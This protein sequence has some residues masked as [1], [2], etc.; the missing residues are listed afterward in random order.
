MAGVPR[1]AVPCHAARA[2]RSTRRAPAAGVRRLP[3]PG[4]TSLEAL[5]AARSLRRHGR[6]SCRGAGG[7]GPCSPSCARSSV[8]RGRATRLRCRAPARNAE[9]ARASDP[10]TMTTDGPRP[11]HRSRA[12]TRPAST[13]DVATIRARRRGRPPDRRRGPAT[14]ASAMRGRPRGAGRGRRRRSDLRTSLVG[15]D[16][17]RDYPTAG[18]SRVTR[19]P[20]DEHGRGDGSGRSR[21]SAG[22]DRRG[23]RRGRDEPGRAGRSGSPIRPRR[24]AEAR[25][26]AVADA[27]AR[28]TVLAGEA[29]GVTL[30][31]VVAI[32]EGVA[33]APPGRRGRWRR[34]G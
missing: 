9:A 20:A 25:R 21:R 22:A 31:P 3:A 30:G 23:A 33:L 28:A 10:A 29:A 16:A 12:G 19:L 34:C 1:G 27:R 13:P 7:R 4:S 17:V 5:I 11:D 15:L 32:T 14:A 6:S 2:A 26:R 8:A 18:S 24:S